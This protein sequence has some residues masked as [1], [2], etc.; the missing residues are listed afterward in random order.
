[1]RTRFILN[2]FY[3]DWIGGSQDLPPPLATPLSYRVIRVEGSCA[4]K[5]STIEFCTAVTLLTFILII[6]SISSPPHSFIPGL[7][8]S[9]SANPSNLSLR[10]LLQD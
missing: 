4:A 3:W 2:N 1:V 8:H 9:F 5:R 6:I 7:K 10:F